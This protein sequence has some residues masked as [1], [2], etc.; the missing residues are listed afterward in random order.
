MGQTSSKLTPTKK[1][2]KPNPNG[3]SSTTLLVL[4]STRSTVASPYQPS[5]PASS[6]FPPSLYSPSTYCSSSPSIASPVTPNTPTP[7]RQTNRL[8]DIL[9]PLAVLNEYESTEFDDTPCK[10]SGGQRPRHIS[11]GNKGIVHS[12]SGNLLGVHEFVIHPGRPLALWE[13]Q[14]RIKSAAREQFERLDVESR[15]ETRLTMRK[16]EKVG[17]RRGC[18]TCLWK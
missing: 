1:L 13:R 14:E 15:A 7:P 16:D 2:T 3:S 8:S 4:S 12:P 10:Q 17:K 5:S 6:T 18:C 9:D 11:L